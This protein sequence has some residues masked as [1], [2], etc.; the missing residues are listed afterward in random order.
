MVVIA[1]SEIVYI[2]VKSLRQNNH[3]IG[4]VCEENDTAGFANTTRLSYAFLS[5]DWIG[6]MVKRAKKQHNIK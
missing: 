6:N 5:F 1:V 4:N 2:I 3:V